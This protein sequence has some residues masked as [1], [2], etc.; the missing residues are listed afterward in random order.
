MK[1]LQI[2][3]NY[4]RNYRAALVVTVLSIDPAGRRTTDDPLDY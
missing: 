3:F 4:A 2:I 1:P